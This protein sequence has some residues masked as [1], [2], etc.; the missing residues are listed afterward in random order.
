[1]KT[2]RYD[3]IWVRDEV[4]EGSVEGCEEKGKG[5]MQN[6]TNTCILCVLPAVFSCLL[7]Y[8]VDTTLNSMCFTVYMLDI[9]FTD[10]KSTYEC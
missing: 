3:R 6:I 8:I 10:S 7:Y 5:E 2:K 4:V 9:I 1:M